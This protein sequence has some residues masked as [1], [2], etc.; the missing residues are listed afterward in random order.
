MWLDEVFHFGTF[1]GDV[2][3]KTDCQELDESASVV[4]DLVSSDI[5]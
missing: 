4:V 3:G 1:V 5:S 2:G